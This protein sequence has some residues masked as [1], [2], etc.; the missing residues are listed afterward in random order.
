MDLWWGQPVLKGLTFG[1][2]VGLRVEVRRVETGLAEAAGGWTKPELP[3]L[4][5]LY[6]ERDTETLVCANV[7]SS[8]KVSVT[9]SESRQSAR[10]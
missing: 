7:N 9:T 4:L 5:G 3:S 8:K 2:Q 1:W 6:E 10:L